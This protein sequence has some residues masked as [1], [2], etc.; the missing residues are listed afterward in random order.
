MEYGIWGGYSYSVG[1]E[2][3]DSIEEAAAEYIRRMSPSETYYPM[4]GDVAEDEYVI[5]TEHEGWT[6]SE[7]KEILATSMEAIR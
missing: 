5:T 7:L 4:W 1:T 6:L 2:E 3:F